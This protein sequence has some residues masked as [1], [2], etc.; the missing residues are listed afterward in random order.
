MNELKRISTEN[1]EQYLWRIGN[2]IDS[3]V[4]GSWSSIVDIINEQL[5]LDEEDYKTESA[6]RKRYRAAKNFYDNCFVNL[7]DPDFEEQARKLKNERIKLQ[8]V[9]LEQNRLDRVDAKKQLYYEYIG[10]AIKTLPMPEFQKLRP[11][12]SGDPEYVLTLADVHYGAKFVSE[13]NEYSP[14]IAKKRF[15]ILLAKLKYFIVEHNVAE[16]SVVCLGDLIQGMLRISDLKLNDSTVVKSVVDVVRLIAN[17]LNELSAYVDITYYHVPTANHSQIRV[18]NAKASELADEDLE[19]IMGNYIKDML[20]NNDRVEV[21]LPEEGK[22]YIEI[23][24][25]YN[26]SILAMHGHQIKNINNSLKDL[27]MLRREFVDYLLLGHYHSGKE[28]PCNEALCHDTE[29]LISPSFI[30]SDPYSD[31]LMLGN[32]SSV[33]IYGF[34][35]DGHTETH[36]LILN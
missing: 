28:I 15:E 32:K 1:E 29:I 12:K 21:I 20:V 35:P 36:K 34:T 33:K 19:Y 8:T 10:E 13:N 31:S 24:S 22:E 30:G 16:I 6:Y 26:H 2:L 27:S 25:A 7:Q 9:R 11:I 18:L 3:G 4:V 17:F 5:G 23:G 14:E